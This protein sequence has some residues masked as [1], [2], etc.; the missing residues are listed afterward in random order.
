MQYKVKHK[1]NQSVISLI[2]YYVSILENI[3]NKLMRLLKATSKQRKAV[4]ISQRTRQV[5]LKYGAQK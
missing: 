5:V 1:N 3:L 4:L 2:N